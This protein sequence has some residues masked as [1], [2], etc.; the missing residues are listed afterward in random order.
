[1]HG[2]ARP[3]PAELEAVCRAVL[4]VMET[5]VRLNIPHVSCGSVA[6]IV[7]AAKER[8]YDNTTAETCPRY[9]GHARWR[10]CWATRTRSVRLTCA[11]GL[12]DQILSLAL[13]HR[14][15]NAKNTS[16]T[17]QHTRKGRT[18]HCNE[19]IGSFGGQCD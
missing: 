7:R 15:H 9:S 18:R 8:G 11:V 3:V 1:M 10:H 14:E 13:R 5:G 2:E 19:A 12:D 16:F 6:A 17:S 4:F